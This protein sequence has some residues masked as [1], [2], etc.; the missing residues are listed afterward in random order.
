MKTHAYDAVCKELDAIT[1]TYFNKLT[2]YSQQ[3][4]ETN[5]QLQQGFLDLAHAKYTMGAQTISQYSYDERMKATLQ[6]YVKKKKYVT[7]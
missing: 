2:E 3:W 6:M 5:Q 4:K 1:I 7:I